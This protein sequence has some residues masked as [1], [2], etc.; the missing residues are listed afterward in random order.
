MI[1]VSK[2]HHYLTVISLSALLQ[3]KS[4]NHKEDFYCLNCF[5]SYTAKN[6]LKEQE[7]ICNNHDNCHIEMPKWFEKILKYNPG[8]KS[9]KVPIYLDLE[10]LLK[11]EQSCQNNPENSYTEKK[12]MHEP[13]GWA[14]FTRCSFNEKENKLNYYK[15]KDC[16][17]KLCKKLKKRAMKINNYEK[18]DMIPLTK[19]EN[20]SYEEQETFHTRE[21]K[22]C[23]DKDD[24]N[25]R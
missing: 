20:K 8:E 15:G 25:K 4:S 16:I 24:K 18:K 17:E 9:F 23:V 13:S 21:K 19:E 11:K 3:G 7:E 14:M 2:K 22:F 10:C 5:N 1:T 12:A 6:K